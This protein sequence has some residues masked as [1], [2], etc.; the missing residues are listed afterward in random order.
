MVRMVRCSKKKD[1]LGPQKQHSGQDKHSPGTIGSCF[2]RADFA[3]KIFVPSQMLLPGL[4][5]TISVTKGELL[6]AG[7]FSQICLL[8]LLLRFYFVLKEIK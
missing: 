6:K 8:Y 3:R 5:G 7:V 2:G 4:R 1:I